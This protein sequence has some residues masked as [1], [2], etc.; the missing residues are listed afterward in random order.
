MTTENFTK[1]IEESIDAIADS[2]LSWL[3]F[4]KEFYNN[5]QETIKNNEEIGITAN[6]PDKL[7][8]KC[9]KPMVI[10]RNKYGRLFYGCSE[11]PRCLGILGID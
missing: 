4:A 2:K 10:R 6:L 8:P 9:K 1:R 3:D 5:L 7:C 11:Y